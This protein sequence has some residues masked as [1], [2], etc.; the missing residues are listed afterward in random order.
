MSDKPL[1]PEEQLVGEVIQAIGQ[2]DEAGLR[3]ALADLHPAESAS[4]RTVTAP[5]GRRPE[6]GSVMDD[7]CR[8]RGAG[9]CWA[10]RNMTRLG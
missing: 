2:G 10:V 9:L 5:A 3:A 6:H 1:S 7:R 4:N 8:A